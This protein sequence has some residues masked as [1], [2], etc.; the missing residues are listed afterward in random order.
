MHHWQGSRAPHRNLST[1]LL[2]DYEDYLDWLEN[3]AA[4]PALTQDQLILLLH[5]P[6]IL[7]AVAT[8]LSL[9]RI[10]AIR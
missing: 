5:S 7:T 6:A 10:P 9:L 1:V 8:F 2:K 3:H 4:P